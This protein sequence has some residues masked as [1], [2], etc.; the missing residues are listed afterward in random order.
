MALEELEAFI[1]QAEE[2]LPTF[3]GRFADPKIFKQP[4]EL[5]RLRAE[6]DALR[7]DLADA[8]ASWFRRAE[9]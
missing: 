1:T 9:A 6:Y 4:A 7:T 2:R 8:E 3:D 5:A